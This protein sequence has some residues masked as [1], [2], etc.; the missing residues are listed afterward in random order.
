MYIDA[1][2]YTHISSDHHQSQIQY[3]FY[4]LMK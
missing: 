1:L 3:L 4:H 2:Q